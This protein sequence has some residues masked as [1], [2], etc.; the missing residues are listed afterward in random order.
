MNVKNIVLV[1]IAVILIIVAVK[2]ISR[3]NTSG[4][5]LN[6][7]LEDVGDDIEEGMQDAERKIE[8]AVD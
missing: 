3:P 7:R 4:D 2:M 8:D 5:D 6:R 1:A